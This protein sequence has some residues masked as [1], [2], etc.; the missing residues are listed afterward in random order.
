MRFPAPA[1]GLVRLS[2]CHGRSTAYFWQPLDPVPQT[3]QLREHPPAPELCG[4]TASV[5][6]ACG[7][8]LVVDPPQALLADRESLH[9]PRVELSSA[10]HEDLVCRLL[11]E[12]KK[13]NRPFAPHR[14][15][16]V[17]HRESPRT[18]RPCLASLTR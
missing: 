4:A 1:S 10:H 7:R 17:P 6:S 16:S 14:H 15:E 12:K 11:L 18:H 9:D 8:Q 3:S 2:V 13:T 5:D